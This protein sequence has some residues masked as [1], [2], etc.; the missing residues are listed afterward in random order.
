MTLVHIRRE[1][2]A[3]ATSLQIVPRQGELIRLYGDHWIFPAG[4]YE[5][6]SVVHTIVNMPNSNH[7]IDVRLK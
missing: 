6:E 7:H 4:E 5:V 3:I 1:G 2:K